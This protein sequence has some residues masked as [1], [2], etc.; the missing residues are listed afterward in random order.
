M[1]LKLA[2]IDQKWKFSIFFAKSHILKCNRSRTVWD[3]LHDLKNV[4]IAVLQHFKNLNHT[5]GYS[6][7]VTFFCTQKLGF[8]SPS[9]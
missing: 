9:V 4:K 8:T 7:P 2:K 1:W 6:K 5:L 3:V